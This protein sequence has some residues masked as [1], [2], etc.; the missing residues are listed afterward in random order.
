MSHST[1]LKAPS[2]AFQLLHHSPHEK[3]NEPAEMLPASKPLDDLGAL[4]SDRLLSEMS[5]LC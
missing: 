3:N 4:F 2:S 1:M 5:P